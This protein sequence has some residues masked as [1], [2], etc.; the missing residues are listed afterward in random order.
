MNHSS[1]PNFGSDRR[2]KPL[3]PIRTPSACS[4]GHCLIGMRPDKGVQEISELPFDLTLSF[5]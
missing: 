4:R 5:F 3:F 2:I 1:R